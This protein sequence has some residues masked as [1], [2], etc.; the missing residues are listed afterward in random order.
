MVDGIER[1]Q[2]W[3][4]SEAPQA[5]NLIQNFSLIQLFSFVLNLNFLLTSLIYSFLRIFHLFFHSSPTSDFHFSNEF[6]CA[7]DAM[8]LNSAANESDNFCDLSPSADHRPWRRMHQ[9][10]HH[11]QRC[12][13]SSS[14][15]QQH[16]A[17]AGAAAAARANAIAAETTLAAAPSDTQ[18]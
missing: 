11:P 14:R 9:Q 13:R 17:A 8:H 18:M 4:G 3:R 5:T 12:S 16:W 2:Q 7:V 10:R 15:G 1:T 6:S